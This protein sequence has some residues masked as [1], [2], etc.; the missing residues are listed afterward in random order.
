MISHVPEM[1]HAVS[2]GALVLSDDLQKKKTQNKH[3]IKFTSIL[4]FMEKNNYESEPHN[5][6]VKSSQTWTDPPSTTSLETL[7]CNILSIH[8]QKSLRITL[9]M[10]DQVLPVPLTSFLKNVSEFLFCS[11]TAHAKQGN[12]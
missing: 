8:E 2:F 10:I 11:F 4:T 6:L 7:G 12:R 5:S 9:F 3:L 1:L